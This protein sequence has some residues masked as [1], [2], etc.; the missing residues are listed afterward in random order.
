MKRGLIFV[1]GSNM[2]III[3]KAVWSVSNATMQLIFVSPSAVF[4]TLV[5]IAGQN[6]G[7]QFSKHVSD[8]DKSN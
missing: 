7:A 6:Q 8:I 3:L 5:G 2:K 4:E 1:I